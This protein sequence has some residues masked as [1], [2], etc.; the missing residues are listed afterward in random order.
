M[1]LYTKKSNREI[2]VDDDFDLSILETHFI[3]VCGSRIRYA[4]L[5]NK[6]T[7][8]QT[9]LHRYIMRPGP[10]MIVDHINHNGLDNR[11]SNL[12]VCTI[13]DNNKNKRLREGTTSKYKGVKWHRVNSYWVAQIGTKNRVHLGVFINEEDA[14]IAYDIAAIQLYGE[15]AYLNIIT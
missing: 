4:V 14:A 8:T 6:A 1:K 10:D 9:L 5:V 11:V 12:R 7:N 13:A 2:L 3:S 15:Y